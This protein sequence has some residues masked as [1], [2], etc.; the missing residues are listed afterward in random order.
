ME[1]VPD[2]GGVGEGDGQLLDVE[3]VD[4]A[5]Q[6]PAVLCLEVPLLVGQQLQHGAVAPVGVLHGPPAHLREEVPR[7]HV[8]GVEVLRQ[9]GDL[10]AHGHEA[11]LRE[12][13]AHLVDVLQRAV[14]GVLPH[15]QLGPHRLRAPPGVHDKIGLLRASLHTHARH[16]RQ[17]LP[18]QRR[19]HSG[20][21]REQPVQECR[22][23][24]GET[25]HKHRLMY[26]DL[27]HIGSVL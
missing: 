12:V 11:L 7:V 2:D 27:Q 4:G 24:P 1:C 9:A 15:L 16:G 22:T 21:Q 14:P 5:L 18:E 20:V 13:V 10:V 17:E 6:H 25:H 19:A 23:G 26:S 8:H 3:Q